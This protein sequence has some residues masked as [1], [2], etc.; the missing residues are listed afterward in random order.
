[1]PASQDLQALRNILEQAH[2]I[3]SSNPL[4]PGGRERAEELLR[5]AVALSGA[6]VD[7]KRAKPAAAFLGAKGGKQTAKRGPEYF[8][9]ISAMRKTRAGG[10][11]RKQAK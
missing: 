5:T 4:P 10:R 3:V 7:S 11:P 1:V 2:L 9:K 8:A 6:L